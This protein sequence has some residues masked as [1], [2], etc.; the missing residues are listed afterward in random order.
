MCYSELWVHVEC[1]FPESSMGPQWA[2]VSY[3]TGLICHGSMGVSIT[4]TWFWNYTLICLF[5]FCLLY[6]ASM[7]LS[8]FQGHSHGQTQNSLVPWSHTTA[9]FT[10]PHLQFSCL[11]YF[12]PVLRHTGQRTC[13]G[14]DTCWCCFPN[15][16]SS[17]LREENSSSYHQMAPSTF[18]SL[19]SPNFLGPLDLDH[20]CFSFFLF[21]F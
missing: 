14:W 8:M 2:L 6:T 15:L 11:V 18:E 17:H 16:F 5:N 10:K 4:G 19:V 3:T 13:S 21:F 12:S 20:K 7:C 1:S 9:F